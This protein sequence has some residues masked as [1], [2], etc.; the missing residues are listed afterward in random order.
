[1]EVTDGWLEFSTFFFSNPLF[2]TVNIQNYKHQITERKGGKCGIDITVSW[3]PVIL[4][5]IIWNID[6]RREWLEKK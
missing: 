3:I 1:M 6:S 5:F 2:S 4:C